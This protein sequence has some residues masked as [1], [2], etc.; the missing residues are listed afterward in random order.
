MWEKGYLEVCNCEALSLYTVEEQFIVFS[1]WFVAAY[2]FFC[3]CSGPP[4]KPLNGGCI[5]QVIK[6]RSDKFKVG[7]YVKADFGCR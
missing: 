2:I 6:S 1:K 4:V 3:R 7:D 5:G